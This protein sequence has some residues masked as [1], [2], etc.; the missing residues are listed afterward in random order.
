MASQQLP[1]FQCVRDTGG[2]K[3]AK[4][5]VEEDDSASSLECTTEEEVSADT[6]SESDSELSPLKTAFPRG[7]RNYLEISYT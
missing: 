4:I 7:V 6:E 2:T 5:T 1:L 3:R